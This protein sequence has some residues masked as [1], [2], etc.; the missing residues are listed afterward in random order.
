MEMRTCPKGHFYDGDVNATCPVCEAEKKSMRPGTRANRE[1]TGLPKT[2]GGES[3]EIGETRAVPG[4]DAAQISSSVSGK[5]TGTNRQADPEENGNDMGHRTAGQ[6]VAGLFVSMSGPDRGQD[7]RIHAGCN[8][9][10]YGENADIRLVHGVNSAQTGS[11]E[12]TCAL[13]VYDE[14]DRSFCCFDTP[15]KENITRMNGKLVMIPSELHRGDILLLGESELLF[16]PL[17]REEFI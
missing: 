9:I 12:E 14:A 5:R 7:Y 2:D 17:D 15:K 11:G 13:L 10:G 3:S 8:V 4:T 1:V 16:L 6:P